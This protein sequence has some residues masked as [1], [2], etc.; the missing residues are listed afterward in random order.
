MD[1]ERSLNSYMGIV[2]IIKPAILEQIVPWKKK[3][4]KKSTT[5]IIEFRLDMTTHWIKA[6]YNFCFNHAVLGG[7]GED[8]NK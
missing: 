4:K 6:M 1:Y 3:K 2:K 5:M 8:I 7:Q